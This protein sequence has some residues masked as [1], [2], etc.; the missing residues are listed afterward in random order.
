[1]LKIL[2]AYLLSL[3]VSSHSIA[4]TLTAPVN[5]SGTIVNDVTVS[6]YGP[7]TFGT[8]NVTSSGNAKAFT[9]LAFTSDVATTITVCPDTAN[10]PEWSYNGGYAKNVVLSGIVLLS[11]KLNG[12]AMPISCMP[13]QLPSG[14]QIQ[15]LEAT[16]TNQTKYVGQI[17][18]IPTFQV[19]F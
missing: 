9:Q 11:F 16:L 6:V 14:V 15:I 1:M 7:I 17:N 2:L 3:V 18:V 10:S 5:I 12:V 19:I 4:G 13:L 8:M